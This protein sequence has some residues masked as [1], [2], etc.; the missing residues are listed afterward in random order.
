MLSKPSITYKTFSFY[1]DIQDHIVK[2]FT[3]KPF[4]MVF[5][6]FGKK[7]QLNYETVYQ[8]H[9]L[10]DVTLCPDPTESPLTQSV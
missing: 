1:L 8:Y 9:Q 5:S 7:F 3:R 4:F 2:R 10:H 6:C